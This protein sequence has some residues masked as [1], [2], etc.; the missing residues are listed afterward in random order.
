M[1]ITRENFA[2]YGD[3]ISTDSV[4]PIDINSGYAKRFDDLAKINTTKDNG[5]TIISIFRSKWKNW[6][7]KSM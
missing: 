4:K 7:F 1:E 6:W 5:K 3:L 2:S